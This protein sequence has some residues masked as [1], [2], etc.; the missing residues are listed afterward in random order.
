MDESCK[1]GWQLFK[2][3]V[4]FKLHYASSSTLRI[5]YLISNY[6]KQYFYFGCNISHFTF[7][8]VFDQANSRVELNFKI[9]LLKKCVY[10]M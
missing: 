9:T 7:I 1:W 5:L 4:G 8:S 2:D 10:L 3:F 6:F